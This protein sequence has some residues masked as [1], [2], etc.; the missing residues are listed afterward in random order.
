M[1]RQIQIPLKPQKHLPYILRLSEI[2]YGVVDGVVVFKPEQRCQ[3]ALVEF[4]ATDADKVGQYKVEAVLLFG[5]E[6]GHDAGP[7]VICAF[8][9]LGR[10]RQPK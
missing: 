2:R 4:F 3:L 9:A 10:G 6:P 5:V 8:L 1:L 7:G